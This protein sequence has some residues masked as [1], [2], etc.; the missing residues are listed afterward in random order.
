MLDRV[1]LGFV[2]EMPLARE[3]GR[4]ALLLEELVDRRGFLAQEVLI[5]RRDDDRQRRADG[6]GPG[7]Q[8]GPS[9]GAPRLPLQSGGIRPFLAPP[10]NVGG[11]MADTSTSPLL[12]T[13]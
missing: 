9:S 11:R 10:I 6:N 13:N 3:V 1:G 4:V 2:A 12:I 8:P 5:T 7:D